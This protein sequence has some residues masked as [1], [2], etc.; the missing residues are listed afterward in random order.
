VKVLAFLVACGLAFS[1]MLLMKASTVDAAAAGQNPHRGTESE[2]QALDRCGGEPCDA[3]ARGLR[4]FFDRRLEDLGGNGRSCADCHMATDNFQLS[5]ASVEARFRL[6][7]LR[8]RSDPDAD[9]PLFRPIDADDFRTN[10]EAAND[11][12]NLRQNGLVRITF[13]LPPNI[14]LVDPATNSL[15]DE[16]FVDVWRM[17]PSVNDVALTGPD[18]VIPVWPRDPN[19]T[20]GYQLDARISTLQ[21][22]ALGALTNHAEIQHAPPPQ[23]LD[24]LSS[25]QRVLFTKHR[26]RA[27]ADAV[28]EGQVVLPDPD[29]P[30]N[31]L[32]Q[33]GKAVFARACSQ[34]HGG[35]GQSTPQ[36]PVIRF[37]RIFSQ[38]PRPV[39]TATPPR[40]VFAACSPT[41]ARNA[42]TY[43]IA[44][45]VPTASPTGLLPAGTKVRRTSS[46]PGRALLTGFIGGPAPSDD[47]EKFDIPGLRGIRKTAPYFHNNS[48]TT[49]EEVVDHYIAFFKLVQANTPPGAPAPPLASTDG[50]HFDRRPTPE[51][52]AALIA[53]LR[54][55]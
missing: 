35:P 53:Y 20:G 45:S 14:R 38:C 4:A 47:W 9:D 37:H 26:V 34:C 7:Q 21:E 33:E 31:E 55:L 11:F 40:F 5:P 54:K 15:S 46:D 3:V 23:L 48:A 16:T 13:P 25:F 10:G 18:H 32:E 1:S 12:G 24:D 2:R 27:L 8:R 51:E 36:F 17:V 52:R 28:R 19:P 49:L 41:L 29:P 6:L 44:L 43:E 39:D 42:R 50:V 22:Q 30:L